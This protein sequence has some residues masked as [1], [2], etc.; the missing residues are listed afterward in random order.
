M[1][2]AGNRVVRRHWLHQL[3]VGVSEDSLVG[4]SWKNLED[5]DLGERRSWTSRWQNRKSE[6]RLGSRTSCNESSGGEGEWQFGWSPRDLGR[7]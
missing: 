4:L 6:Q 1:E 5:F 7:E 3:E 2:R